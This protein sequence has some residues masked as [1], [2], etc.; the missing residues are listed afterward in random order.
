MREPT[1]QIIGEDGKVYTCLIH[2]THTAFESGELN[3]DNLHGNV[4][5]KY[6]GKEYLTGN[7]YH[8]LIELW[9][10]GKFY[11]TVRMTS[12]KVCE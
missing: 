1:Q 10:D 7:R 12:I 5:V 9:L 2:D 3:E 4:K 11:R 8:D 6:R